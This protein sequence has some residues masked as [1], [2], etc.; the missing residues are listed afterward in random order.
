MQYNSLRMSY[1]QKEFCENEIPDCDPEFK[2]SL[3]P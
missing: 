1:K 3:I 2:L